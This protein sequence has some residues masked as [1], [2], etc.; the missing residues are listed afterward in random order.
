MLA[1]L[2]TALR[3]ARLSC[4]KSLTARWSVLAAARTRTAQES[5][6]ST[7]TARIPG[8]AALQIH[9]VLSDGIAE[10]HHVREGHRFLDDEALHE[11]QQRYVEATPADA[12]RSRQHA[13]EEQEGGAVRVDR[14]EREQ[15]LVQADVALGRL[16]LGAGPIEHRIGCQHLVD[17]AQSTRAA[18]IV[19]CV[20]QERE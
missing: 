14:T 8:V 17:N 4:L 2:V 1:A 12:R 7:R 20:A 15:T 5:R 11:H 16:W 18:C 13:G 10:H 3:L 9:Q 19:R 6:I